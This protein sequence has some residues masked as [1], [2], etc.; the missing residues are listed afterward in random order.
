MNELFAY[1]RDLL[2][3]RRGPQDLPYSPALTGVFFL[4]A[5][6]ADLVLDALVLGE[7]AALPRVAVADGLMLLLPY[8]ALAV[9]GRSAFP[10]ASPCG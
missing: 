8:L 6:A 9:A 7:P 4:A 5:V 3:L 10:H 1:T 2:R